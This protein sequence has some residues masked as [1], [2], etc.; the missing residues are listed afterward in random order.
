MFQLEDIT[1]RYL[2]RTLIEHWAENPDIRPV[3]GN[4]L[5]GSLMHCDVTGF[6]AMSEKLAE[7]GKEGAELMAGVLNQF[8]ERML[9]IAVSWGGIQMK[10]GGD[11]MLLYFP[12]E[13]HAQR[14][15]ACGLEMQSAMREFS[16]VRVK[17]DY[18]K[19]RMRIGIH[20][21]K[22]YVC[23]VGQVGTKIGQGEGLLHYYIVGEDVNIAADTEPMAEPGQVVI[24]SDTYE[25][26]DKE[27]N[28]IEKTNHEGIWLAKKVSAKKKRL[29]FF[30]D[31]D[32]PHHILHRYLMKPIAEG[33]S[34]GKSEH[35]RVTIIFIYVT[36]IADLLKIN[37]EEKALSQ[38]DKYTNLVIETAEKYGGHFAASDASEHGDKLIVLFGAP[39]IQDSQESSAMHFAIELKE[40]MERL[41][42]DMEHQIGINTGYV[43]CGEIGSTQRREYTVIGDSVNLSARLMAAANNN[44]IIVSDFTAK[45]AKNEFELESL[46]PIMVKGKK[47][48]ISICKLKGLI[49]KKVVPINNEKHH[50]YG[51]KAEMQ[52]INN[53]FGAVKEESSMSLLLYGE[54]GVGKTAIASEFLRGLDEKHKQVEIFCRSYDKNSAYSSIRQ[55]IFSVSRDNG[56]ETDNRF[57]IRKLIDRYAD[58]YSEFVPLIDEII[59]LDYQ[60]NVVTASLDAKTRREKRLEMLVE[61]ISNLSSYKPLVIFVD[62]MQWLD[63]SSTEILSNIM[64]RDNSKVFI[65]ATARQDE[66]LF[67]SPDN[68]FYVENLLKQD[69]IKLLTD[70]SDVNDEDYLESVFEKTQGN[71]LFLTELVNSG[72]LEEGNLP[73]S[74]Y[75]IVIAKMDKLTPDFKYFLQSTSVVGRNIK[76]DEIAAII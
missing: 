63:S 31:T 27:S 61:M 5:E 54:P 11:A 15:A 29:K 57:N 21:G 38:L 35:R 65:I 47:D 50:F 8:F 37:N 70:I 14:A 2:P 69:A 25:L 19:L 72:N 28:R 22:F 45:R 18:H 71:P 40:I 16:R 30:D 3:W 4:W 51:R 42:L 58:Q 32:L 1:F 26:F 10:F 12:G 73:D 46:E 64:D 33:L 34:S 48:P 6:T 55:F 49:N 39:V 9:A 62:N 76:T 44:E 7:V 75:D 53:I 68:K 17:D 20:A 59:G 13:E 36:G 43:F 67:F 23:S 66:D 74:L 41:D 52:M 24:S 60:D 56:A